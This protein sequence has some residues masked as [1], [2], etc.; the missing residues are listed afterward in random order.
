MMK[1][2]NTLHL[3]ANHNEDKPVTVHQL[4]KG[5]NNTTISLQ[6]MG[7]ERLK[8]HTTNVPALL[9]CVSG[10]AVYGE[11]N[12]KRLQLFPGNYVEIPVDV[13]HFVEATATSQFILI[14]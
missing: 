10:D 5:V 3:Q 9:I 14:K 6:I 2:N 7:G 12:G 1:E 11:E 8:E 4:F 13:V